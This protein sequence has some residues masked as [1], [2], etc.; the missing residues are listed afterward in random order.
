MECDTSIERKFND[1]KTFQTDARL[2]MI[3]TQVRRLNVSI[4]VKHF[5]VSIHTNLII[6]LFKQKYQIYFLFLHR[7]NQLIVVLV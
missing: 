7:L 6:L 1:G 5:F 2:K 4:L 3:Y